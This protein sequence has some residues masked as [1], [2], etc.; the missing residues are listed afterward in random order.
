MIEVEFVIDTNGQASL[1][2]YKKES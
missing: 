1:I 2:S